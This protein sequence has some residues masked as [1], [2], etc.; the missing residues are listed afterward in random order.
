VAQPS[1][2]QAGVKLRW[3][4]KPTVTL[5]AG[6][7]LWAGCRPGVVAWE[8]LELSVTR[9]TLLFMSPGVICAFTG[10]SAAV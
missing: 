9:S 3:A 5:W 2:W 7:P 1:C 4:A 6:S 8:P 10:P